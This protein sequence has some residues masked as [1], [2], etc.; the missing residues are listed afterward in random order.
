M[1]ASIRDFLDRPIPPGMREKCKTEYG[2]EIPEGAS[3]RGALKLKVLQMAREGN[4]E[5]KK[6]VSERGFFNE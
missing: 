6:I 3:F 5:A 2:I 1:D 4:R